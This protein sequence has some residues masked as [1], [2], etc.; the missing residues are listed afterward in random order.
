MKR[1]FSFILIFVLAITWLPSYSYAKGNKVT[2]PARTTIMTIRQ[3]S[4]ASGTA[5]VRIRW[6][7][8]SANCSGYT[9]YYSK[10]KKGSYKAIKSVKG[11]NKT[12]ATCKIAIKKS[13]RIYLAVKPY[14]TVK[15]KKGKKAK[16]VYASV[17]YQKIVKSIRLRTDM[18]ST[19]TGTTN[20][21][22][23]S[24]TQNTVPTPTAAPNVE[25]KNI[26][27]NYGERRSFTDVVRSNVKYVVSDDR[28]TV[29]TS[30]VF[31]DK[32][33]PED[34]LREESNYCLWMQ[35]RQ[36]GTTSVLISLDDNNQIKYNITIVSPEPEYTYETK[37]IK[38]KTYQLYTGLNYALYVKTEN[39]NPGHIWIVD[40]TSWL[41]TS[42][43]LF[44]TKNVYDDIAYLN[45]DSSAVEGG[46]VTSLKQLN[47]GSNTFYIYEQLGEE[48]DKGF[49]YAGSFTI[50]GVL[51]S[52][53]E[54]DKF[55]DKAVDNAKNK[56]EAGTDTHSST[57]WT[58][59][60]RIWLQAQDE[61][62]DMIAET[63]V[64][65]YRTWTVPMGFDEFSRILY[66]GEG[67]WY[68]PEH[69]GLRYTESMVEWYPAVET[70][71]YWFPSEGVY[72]DITYNTYHYKVIKEYKA[73]RTMSVAPFFIQGIG[74]CSTAYS[75][76]CRLTEK[77]GWEYK[78]L[79]YSTGQHMWCAAYI[80]GKW[81]DNDISPGP[82][83]GYIGT[84]PEAL[85]LINP[86]TY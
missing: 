22:Y 79:T 61:A 1:I 9:V 76:Q 25:E 58:K 68:M 73:K 56:V 8:V 3:A 82:G 53:K 70:R 14:R 17:S 52:E 26:T 64:T 10:A 71:R 85:D 75:L 42:S 20:S 23:N 59:D 34:Q 13:Q 77:L 18:S 32:N 7:K 5:I 24:A 21:R 45:E 62:T 69:A 41:F 67:Y 35:A 81:V 38:E 57:T 28:S 44:F 11:N 54:Y 6:K 4:Y 37:L 29:Y 16:K 39:P 78:K 80:D 30:W 65:N 84:N 50:D 27:M 19:D 55:L 63:Q 12:F 48:G 15:G 86:L 66:E 51:D 33:K 46:Y 31:I 83:S 72:K 47:E 43:N 40:K 49:A 36:V 60:Q 74:D 2:R